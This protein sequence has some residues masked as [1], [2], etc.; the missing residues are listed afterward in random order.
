MKFAVAASTAATKTWARLLLPFFFF[1]GPFVLTRVVTYVLKDKL[2]IHI[3][4][5][6]SPQ[7]IP[8]LRIISPKAKFT[9]QIFFNTDPHSV[10]E[11]I[12]I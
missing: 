11:N 9:I 1:E 7:Y 2:V 4:S 6:I 10:V 5:D 8:Y 3:Q 12:Q